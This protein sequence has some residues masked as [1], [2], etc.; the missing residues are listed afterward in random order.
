[1]QEL[2]SILIILLT[3]QNIAHQSGHYI[4]IRPRG[5]RVCGRRISPFC[6]LFEDKKGDLRIRPNKQVKT[7]IKTR[8]I[9]NRRHR[10]KPAVSC[11][12]FPRP[13]LRNKSFVQQ[14]SQN[15]KAFAPLFVVIAAA[16]AAPSQDH[17]DSS[18]TTSHW[19]R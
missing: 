5:K 9:D 6:S 10:T 11:H 4:V 19:C 15:K 1:M 7:N 18:P 12:K 13:H 2:V 17:E 8:R 16:F 3:L 14:S